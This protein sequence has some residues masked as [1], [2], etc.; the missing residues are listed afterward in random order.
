MD[1]YNDSLIRKVR[2]LPASR[3]DVAQL[4]GINYTTLSS[5]LNGFTNLSAINREKVSDAVKV[6]TG[7]LE[8]NSFV[9]RY[10]CINNNMRPM[11]IDE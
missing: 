9:E 5:W 2:E 4:T 1:W 7:K 3:K 11:R 8:R 6:F 10:G